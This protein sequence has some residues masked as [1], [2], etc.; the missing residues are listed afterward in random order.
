MPQ[1]LISLGFVA[2]ALALKVTFAYLIFVSLK[3]ISEGQGI[4]FP[5]VHILSQQGRR[6][7]LFSP[8][9]WNFLYIVLF[10]SH[11]NFVFLLH[12]QKS[13]MESKQLGQDHHL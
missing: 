5:V 7:L 9:V 13:W 12:I 3:R 1:T 8:C 11:I 4:L 10:Y 6:E 2:V